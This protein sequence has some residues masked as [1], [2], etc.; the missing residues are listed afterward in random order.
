MWVEATRVAV[1]GFAVVFI[2]LAIL[3][4]S[5]KVMSFVCR[6]IDKKGGK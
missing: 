4:G 1:I 6:K 5:V 3:A 2:T